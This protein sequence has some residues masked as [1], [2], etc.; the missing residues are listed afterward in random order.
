MDYNKE[1]SQDAIELS[2]PRLHY[3]PVGSTTK[4]PGSSSALF[5]ASGFRSKLSLLSHIHRCA[6]RRDVMHV[7]SD[8][9]LSSS[10]LAMTRVQAFLF[11][12]GCA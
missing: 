1:R 9:Q 6:T 8:F 11:K 3:P 4:V 10:S 12:L 5:G 7:I 2:S